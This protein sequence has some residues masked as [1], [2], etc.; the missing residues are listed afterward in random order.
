MFVAGSDSYVPISPSF[1]APRTDAIGG[2]VATVMVL[3]LVFRSPDASISARDAD[4]STLLVRTLSGPPRAIR[5]A[6]DSRP[7]PYSM[8]PG[9]ASAR[10]HRGSINLVHHAIHGLTIISPSRKATPRLGRRP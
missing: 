4:S 2:S 8:W 6:P 5:P 3:D 9:P 10:C 7:I 1:R